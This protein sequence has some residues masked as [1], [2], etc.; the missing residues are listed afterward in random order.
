MSPNRCVYLILSLSAVLLAGFFIPTQYCFAEGSGYIVELKNGQV[1]TAN[2]CEVKGERLHLSYPVG[3]ATIPLSLVESVK[4]D[5]TDVLSILQTEGEYIP[6]APGP[7]RTAD[8][9]AAQDT[10]NKQAQTGDTG[11]ALPE[12]AAQ[13][14]DGMERFKEFMAA[15]KEARRAERLRNSAGE[16]TYGGGAFSGQADPEVDK[17]IDEAFSGNLTDEQIERK[18]DSLFDDEEEQGR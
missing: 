3:D 5:D 13:P 16:S 17:F 12:Q 15:V 7:E 6:P 11:A 1:L 9:A 4:F 14:V 10:A 8:P 2:A 18:M